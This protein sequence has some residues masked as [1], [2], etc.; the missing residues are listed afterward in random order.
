M[1]EPLLKGDLEGGSSRRSRDRKEV[2]VETLSLVELCHFFTKTEHLCTTLMVALCTALLLGFA[3]DCFTLQA[4]WTSRH[5]HVM[6]SVIFLV[7]F[8]GLSGNVYSSFFREQLVDEV[9]KQAALRSTLAMN[10]DRLSRVR[11][12]LTTHT[13]LLREEL[14]RFEA[15]RVN[16]EK[17]TSDTIS[18]FGD[19]FEK[20]KRHLTKTESLLRDEMRAILSKVAQFYELQDKE[21]GFTEVEW[22]GFLSRLPKTNDAT[23]VL[24]FEKISN[25][26]GI[27]TFEQCQTVID[28]VVA[29][30][31]DLTM[32]ALVS[33][34]S[35]DHNSCCGST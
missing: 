33:N 27:V 10:V 30:I 12:D 6:T 26:S 1:K 4:V 31:E 32:N 5:P 22:R 21:E 13:D 23:I 20:A 35:S 29:S 14:G 24:D 25:G 16:F 18:D 9:H 19:F 3:I 11:K 15:L 8:L 17:A 7:T 34:T 28:K 2:G